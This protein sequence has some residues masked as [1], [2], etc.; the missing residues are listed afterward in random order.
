MGETKK[1]IGVLLGAFEIPLLPGVIIDVWEETLV[2]SHHHSSQSGESSSV[3]VLA[4]A[5]KPRCWTTTPVD[6]IGFAVL[7]RVFIKTSALP[8]AAGT[9]VDGAAAAPGHQTPNYGPIPGQPNT[10]VEAS[11]FGRHPAKGNLLM[12]CINSDA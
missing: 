7:E 11:I 6:G 2:E 5:S 3:R 4:S 10:L 8:S 1:T 9:D 12:E